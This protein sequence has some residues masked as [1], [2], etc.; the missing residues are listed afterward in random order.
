MNRYPKQ[1]HDIKGI[2]MNMLYKYGEEMIRTG[3]KTGNGGEIRI[4][5]PSEDKLQRMLDRLKT[6]EELKNIAINIDACDSGDLFAGLPKS[7]NRGDFLG[8]FDDNEIFYVEWAGKQWTKG[9][10]EWDWFMALSAGK[11]ARWLVLDLANR[12]ECVRIL[13]THGLDVVRSRCSLTGS[14]L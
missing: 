7:M 9:S 5:R 1:A 4:V 3:C 11:T 14:S 2:R 6:K 8:L 13:D 10:E 12:Y